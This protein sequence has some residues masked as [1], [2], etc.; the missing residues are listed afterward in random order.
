MRRE[1]LNLS[2]PPQNDRP[3][4]RWM[5]GHTGN[6][7]G[8]GP[9]TTGLM[10][11]G[12]CTMAEPCKPVRTWHGRRK[13]AAML[14]TVGI[15]V[16]LVAVCWSSTR[17]SVVKPGELSTP[18]AQILAGTMDS[19]RCAA[20]H[21]QA[22]T[23]V[24]DWFT[25]LTGAAVSKA[26][27]GISQSDRCLNCHHVTIDRSTAGFAHN[28]PP[29]IR[30]ELRLASAGSRDHSWQDWL[31]GAAVNQ[32]DVKC[33]AC[34][35]EHR[36]ADGKLTAMTNDQCQTCHSDRFGDFASSHPKWNDWPYRR[37]GVIA[38]DHASHATKHFPKTIHE[39]EPLPFQCFDCHARGG[40][41]ELTRSTSYEKACQACHDA[42]LRIETSTGVDLVALPSVTTIA[43]ESMGPWPAEAI[44]F[45]DGKVTAMA[46]LLMRSDPDLNMAIRRLPQ[47]D[48]SRLDDQRSDDVDAAREVARGLRTLIEDISRGGQSVMIDRIGKSGIGADSVAAMIQSL[49][50]QLIEEA[51]RRW[52]AVAEDSD[53]LAKQFV[54]TDKTK[55][56]KFRMQA[57]D[58]DVLGDDDLLGDDLLD[59]SD[60]LDDGDLL[61]DS[62]LLGDD[63]LGGGDPLAD[64]PLA[65]DPLSS[66]AP[67]KT[68]TISA[69]FDADSMLPAGGWYRD[70][71]TFSVRYR[72]NGH[73]DP[74]IRAT[75]EMAAQLMPGDPARDRMLAS[76]A[77]TACIECHPGALSTASRNLPPTPSGWVS[78]PLIRNPT[79][80]RSGGFTK[81]THG[82]HLNIAGLSDCQHCHQINRDGIVPTPRVDVTTISA[83]DLAPVPHEFMPMGIE[84]CAGCHHRDAA[85]DACIKC[86][87]YH[88]DLP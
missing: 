56:A 63:L 37:G 77:V 28:L 60:L 64:D 62:D 10:G 3:G 71:L 42:A 58:D 26:H 88:I 45:F 83:S 61:S 72:G 11:R 39:G 74:V 46:E 35:R 70:D 84:T 33:S 54:Q 31:P 9:T 82:P 81:F 22:G 8:R 17:A 40:D 38:F 7:C 86:H 16:L 6:P 53:V 1:D 73:A 43:A 36:G 85:G 23:S 66:P 48:F 59:D 75:I 24:G 79:L 21:Q 87:R 20:C 49:P 41:G 30:T 34:H 80:H 51:S 50:P 65:E 13:Q 32:E 19:G 2:A 76:K 67:Q 44:G 5:C 57:G 14:G 68:P 78:D 18:H 15:V 47:R 55:L 12:R 69:R 29:S 4:D 25:S 52:F 27:D